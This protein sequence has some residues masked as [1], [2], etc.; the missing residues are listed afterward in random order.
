MADVIFGDFRNQRMR[1]VAAGRQRRG[2]QRVPWAVFALPAMIIAGNREQRRKSRLRR[3]RS[4][5]Q[6]GFEVWRGLGDVAPEFEL[7]WL[8]AVADLPCQLA[9]APGGWSPHPLA[10]RAWGGPA[11]G[12]PLIWRRAAPPIKARAFAVCRLYP[13]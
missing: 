3:W 7:E 1:P 8:S 5:S 2:E 12:F 10:R 4:G 6:D 13:T 9:A 11:P